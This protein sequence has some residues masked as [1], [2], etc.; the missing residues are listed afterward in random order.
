MKN[1]F[2]KRL[3]ELRIEKN[4]TQEQLADILA[5]LPRTVS[6]WENGKREC[7]FDTLIN[8]ADFFQSSIDFLLGYQN[9]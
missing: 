5:V 1:Q 2:S 4:L 7:D 9:K 3:K 8:I 6:Y